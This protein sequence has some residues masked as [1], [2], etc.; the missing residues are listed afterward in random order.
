MFTHPR[1]SPYAGSSGRTARANTSLQHNSLSRSGS[2]AVDSPFNLGN[3]LP[4]LT[5]CG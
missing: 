1:R 4:R 2:E 3:T 5:G